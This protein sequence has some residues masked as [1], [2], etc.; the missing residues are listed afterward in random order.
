MSFC[1][2]RCTV[3]GCLAAF[4]SEELR[5]RHESLHI[6]NTKSMFKCSDCDKQFMS[7]VILRGH[8]HKEHGA[9]FG[10]IVCPMCSMF[11]TYRTGTCPCVS[12]YFFWFVNV[13]LVMMFKHMMIHSDVKPFLCSDC[14]KSFRQLSQ[15]KN[16]EACH[17]LPDD[18]R[19]LLIWKPVLL[20][21]MCFRCPRGPGWKSAINA[22][23]FSRIPK[24]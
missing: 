5:R 14:G 15:L 22:I 24:V 2:C 11:K 16:H 21:W 3:R 7:W 20:N 6:G 19:R 18:V 4:P 1:N 12:R 9:D 13:L 10:M 8:M 17:K 23:S